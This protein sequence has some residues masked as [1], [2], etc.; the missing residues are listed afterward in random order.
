M[1]KLSLNQ[2][3]RFADLAA[4]PNPDNLV[5]RSATDLWDHLREAT[6]VYG[7]LLSKELVEEARDDFPVIAIHADEFRDERVSFSVPEVSYEEY[8]NRM[9]LG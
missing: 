8:L 1:S 4:V 6:E 5:L 2:T 7:A 3:G 9:K